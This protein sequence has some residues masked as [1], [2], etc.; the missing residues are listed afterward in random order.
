MTGVRLVDI[1]SHIVSTDTCRYPVAP[2]EGVR[3]AWSV[4]RPVTFEQYIACMNVAG[5]DKAVIVHSPTTYGFDNA[6]VADSVASMPQRFDGVFTVDMSADDAATQ[7][8]Y[9]AGR[10]LGG[11]RLFNGGSGTRIQARGWD[12]PR[13]LRGWEAATDLSL[14]ICVQMAV[15]DL[16]S[17]VVLLERYPRTR[18]VL[19]HMLR[20]S[21]SDGD[22]YQG[23]QY[24]FD[25][26]RYGNVY[27]KMTRINTLQSR[28][29]K[30]TPASFLRRVV[31]AFGAHRIA[32]GSNFPASD[33]SLVDIVTDLR[34]CIEGLSLEEQAWIQA[35]TALHLYP[36]LGAP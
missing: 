8:G 10:G 4:Q 36:R 18:V 19:D 13:L 14:P 29:G 22:P 33:G 3:S 2:L 6:Y 11:L 35:G 1:H 17:L 16:P 27:L 21:L 12:D 7:I 24:V 9:W 20:P 28:E 23:A 31:R 30:A 15:Q 26:A 5:V 32:W 25:L 34:T